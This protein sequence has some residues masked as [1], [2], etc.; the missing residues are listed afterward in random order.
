MGEWGYVGKHRCRIEGDLF[1]SI[2][3]GPVSL[4]EMQTM[5]GQIEAAVQNQGVRFF[6]M[7]L[8]R[9]EAPSPEARRWMSLNPYQGIEAVAGYGASRTLRFLS[10]LMRRAMNALHRSESRRAP[11]RL[12]ETEAEARAHLQQLRNAP[13]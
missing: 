4:A 12:F 5:M 13:K 11:F 8:T 9:A 10:D 1:V 7:D 3:D 2:N 6:L